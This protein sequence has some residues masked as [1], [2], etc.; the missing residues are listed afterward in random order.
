[1]SNSYLHNSEKFYSL[2]QEVNIY[3]PFIYS[4]DENLKHITFNV[5]DI[6]KRNHFITIYIPDDYPMVKKKMLYFETM[7]PPVT[8]NSLLKVNLNVNYLSLMLYLHRWK[9]NN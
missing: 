9:S 5:I 6:C 2:I 1:M 7:V 3:G 8:M 4:I